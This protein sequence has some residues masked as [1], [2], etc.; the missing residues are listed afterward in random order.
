MRQSRVTVFSQIQRRNLTQ[1][2]FKT[3]IG[4]IVEQDHLRPED[5]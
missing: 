3:E 1:P 2:E 4:E 5:T